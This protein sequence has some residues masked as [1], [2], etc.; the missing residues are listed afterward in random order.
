MVGPARRRARRTPARAGMVTLG[1]PGRRDLAADGMRRAPRLERDPIA[2]SPSRAGHGV[3]KAASEH[4]RWSCGLAVGRD[5]AS[6]VTA[7]A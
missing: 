2:G 5:C 6:S 3:G 7:S 4:P 1:R